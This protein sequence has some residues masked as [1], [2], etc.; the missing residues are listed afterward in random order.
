MPSTTYKRPYEV[1]TIKF[2]NP[3]KPAIAAP[4]PA[5][6]LQPHHDDSVNKV[7]VRKRRSKEGCFNCRKIK[8]KCSETKPCCQRCHRRGFKCV[9]P[10][11]LHER[12]PDD[13][14]IGFVTPA[15]VDQDQRVGSTS[16]INMLQFGNSAITEEQG[17]SSI[18]GT[19]ASGIISTETQ[20]LRILDELKLQ[21][22]NHKSPGTGTDAA[23]SSILSITN[24]LNEQSDFV[25]YFKPSPFMDS[26]GCNYQSLEEYESRP[27]TPG[28][29]APGPSIPQ[30]DHN[31]S[32]IK[33]QFMSACIN[34]F[35][36]AVAPQDTHPSLTTTATF[37]PIFN[38]AN[39]N[40]TILEKV[41][42][43]CG[44]AFL[45]WNN[46]VEMTNLAR[47]LYE[48]AF[49]EIKTLIVESVDSM[50]RNELIW[51]CGASQMLC[52][53]G[54]RLGNTGPSSLIHLK[55]TYKII[56][57]RLKFFEQ[58][59]LE[60]GQKKKNTQ[61]NKVNGQNK[62]GQVTKS[63]KSKFSIGSFA[64]DMLSIEIE[65]QLL[66][67]KSGATIHS[68]GSSA[69]GKNDSSKNDAEV[70]RNQFERM[71]I[72]SFIYN[73][74]VS[75]IT[76]VK[77]EEL[78]KF[79]DPNQVFKDLRTFLKIPIFKCDVVWMNNPV[80][81]AASD[82]FELI[83]KTS[84]LLRQL[85]NPLTI[86]M[87]EKLMDIASFYPS[88][89]IPLEIKSQSEERYIHLKE[90]VLM[91]DIVLKC[92]KALLLKII[93]FE[94]LHVSTPEIQTE[95]HLIIGKFKMMKRGAAVK[96][97]ASWPLFITGLMCIDVEER[98]FVIRELLEVGYSTQSRQVDT[99][100]KVLRDSWNTKNGPTGF[101]I[102]WDEKIMASLCL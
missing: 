69:I 45:S 42:Y 3:S 6:Q 49:K 31:L 8:K 90:S 88:S 56:K 9:W 70:S 24:S 18:F 100:V 78:S 71:F 72:E 28:P 75:L 48:T 55:N 87:A 10:G 76:V 50:G 94:R 44:A 40:N 1:I 14:V 29:P 43:A 12:L 2:N 19:A 74:T 36:R 93:N 13:Y 68:S 85:D 23:G 33:A 54:K 79:P 102:L 17:K 95:V 60:Q 57:A 47:D 37:T 34:G 59:G 64:L 91:S 62:K 41:A 27:T 11:N 58:T 82:A 16:D 89:I 30:Q 15:V 51:T 99:V 63:S 80:L 66:G 21:T 38:H 61:L 77:F 26:P 81:G 52:L 83:G 39:L 97:I 73:Y 98:E 65:N 5:K 86:P 67:T 101:D 20:Y 22:D 53:C 4:T 92:C 25:N 84:Y 96:R 7:K 46:E 35:I 32:A